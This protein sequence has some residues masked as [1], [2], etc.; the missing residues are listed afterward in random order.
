MRKVVMYVHESTNKLVSKVCDGCGE[1]K[2]KEDFTEKKGK[3]FYTADCKTCEG[4]E[5]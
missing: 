2:L 5:A 3:E 1:I 4:E